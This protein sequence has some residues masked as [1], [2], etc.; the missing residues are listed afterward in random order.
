MDDNFGLRL[1]GGSRTEHATIWTLH[2]AV[3]AHNKE[4][5]GLLRDT[6]PCEEVVRNKRLSHISHRLPGGSP[7]LRRDHQFQAGGY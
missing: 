3:S 2:P 1:T 4:L 5:E 6:L 7:Q